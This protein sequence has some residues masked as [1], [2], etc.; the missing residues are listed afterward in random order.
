MKLNDKVQ[1]VSFSKNLFACDFC[2]LFTHHSAAKAAG[3]DPDTI[4]N[5]ADIS[6]ELLEALANHKL[7]PDQIEVVSDASGR[8]RIQSRIDLTEAMGGVE[9]GHMYIAP[10]SSKFMFF[11]IIYKPNHEA[12]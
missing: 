1:Y 8:T 4:S 12:V 6:D 2:F 5:E 9:E 3:V 10:G 11:M 7:T